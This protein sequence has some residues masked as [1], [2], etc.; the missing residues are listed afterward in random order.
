MYSVRVLLLTACLATAVLFHESTAQET[1]GISCYVCSGAEK[2]E[3]GE[4]FK[5]PTET[6]TGSTIIKQTGC[7]AC[8]VTRQTVS[9]E[10]NYFR[11]CDNTDV[12]D[13]G[14]KTE[15]LEE[16]CNSSCKTNL[17]NIGNDSPTL[18]FALTSLIST[19]L[20]SLAAKLL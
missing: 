20:F 1:A 4:D 2:S 7:T 17:C 16:V 18:R 5:A 19:L 10:S 13:D 15:S 3:C 9:G 8:S 6:S 14:C 12:D 11:T